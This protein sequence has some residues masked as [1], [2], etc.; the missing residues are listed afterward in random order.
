[1]NKVVIGVGYGDEGKG[2]TVNYLSNANSTVIRFNGGAQAGH[3]VVHRGFR[4]VFS[5]IGSGTLKGAETHLSKYFVCNPAGFNNEYEHLWK[6]GFSPIVSVDPNAYITT[7]YDIYIN[8]EIERKRHNKHGSVGIGIGETIERSENG[9]PICV[10]DL[11]DEKLLW[12]KLD[13]IKDWAW[14]RHFSLGLGLHLFDIEFYW[15]DF[16]K[17]CQLFLK[18]ISLIKDKE[19]IKKENVIFEGAQGL[20]LDPE[21]GTMPYCTRSNCGLKNIVELC[22]EPC[23][24]YYVSRPYMTR[25]G[26][27]PLPFERVIP[28][29]VVDLTNQPNEFQGSLRY[30]P[31]NLDKIGDVISKEKDKYGFI[32]NRCFAVMSCLDQIDYEYDRVEFIQN[33]EIRY[34]YRDYIGYCYANA[35]DGRFVDISN[36]YN[37]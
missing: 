30:S 9:F 20:L 6:N 17:D 37:Q 35:I 29:H 21:Y 11:L 2:A 27:G 23:D 22:D 4:H 8:R 13:K 10:K 19:I 3:T 12:K 26:A 5:H 25:H 31:L 15:H 36:K 18:R 16:I 7:P 14:D 34:T 24:V 28:D 1:M 32:I 33:N